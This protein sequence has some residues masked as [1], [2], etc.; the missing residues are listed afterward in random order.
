[1]YDEVGLLI[2]VNFLGSGW[3]LD[4]WEDTKGPSHHCCLHLILQSLI[5]WWWRSEGGS[6]P[7][8]KLA[9][10]RQALG[11]AWVSWGMHLL[12]EAH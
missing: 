6:S 4:A 8:Q 1:M 10:K 5:M 2:I 11:G 9:V 3:R 7:Q 12:L